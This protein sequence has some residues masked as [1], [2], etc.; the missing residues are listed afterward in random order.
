MALAMPL[1]VSMPRSARPSMPE[2]ISELP[3]KLLV[4]SLRPGISLRRLPKVGFA[5]G[6]AMLKPMRLAIA[7]AF[8]TILEE[9]GIDWE[10]RVM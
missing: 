4:N 5:T 10:A 3:P 7:K 6:A 2:A 8:L 1:A 9:I